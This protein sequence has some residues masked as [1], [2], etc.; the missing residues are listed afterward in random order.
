MDN[1]PQ[2]KR[3]VTCAESR[4]IQDSCG[5]IKCRNCVLS[6]STQCL[7]CAGNYPGDLDDIIIPKHIKVIL[8]DPVMYKCINCKRQ[9]KVKSHCKYHEHC[10]VSSTQHLLCDIC[11]MKFTS[12]SLLNYHKLSHEN[13][14]PFKCPNCNKGFKNKGKL[15]RHVK[16]HSDIKEKWVCKVCRKALMSIESLRRHMKIHT[17]HKQF[18]CD[19]CEK[20]FIEKH[21]L[22]KHQVTHSSDKHFA[23]EICKKLFKRKYDLTLHMTAH[24]PIPLRNFHCGLCD[25]VFYSYHN[26]KRHKRLH[27]NHKTFKCHDCKKSFTRKDNLER[28][29]KS[30]HLEEDIDS[31]GING[32]LA[33]ESSPNQNSE[34]S[35]LSNNDI[36][37][38][39]NKVSVIQRVPVIVRSKPL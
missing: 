3:V 39:N 20:S 25:K 32:L 2:C 15:N 6:D 4:L 9:F 17:G 27:Q 13:L 7:M 36:V 22:Q 14:N 18:K 34:R 29:V 1:C 33:I 10:T 21:D 5:H 23:C 28:H 37:P 38:V 19:Q 8:G 31:S 30:V 12:K 24:Q 26:M 16:I 11:D 35:V